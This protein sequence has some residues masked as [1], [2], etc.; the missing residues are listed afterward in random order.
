MKSNPEVNETIGKLIH[1]YRIRKGLTQSDLARLLG[2]ESPQFVSNLERGRAG[3]PIETL[4]M[5]CALINLPEKSTVQLMLSTYE[6]ELNKQ[7]LRGKNRIL[8][9]RGNLKLAV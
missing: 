9:Q 4:G 6:R 8:T 1:H 3:V 2:H 5:L 7:I